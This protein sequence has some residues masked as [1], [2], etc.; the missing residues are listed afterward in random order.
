MSKYAGNNLKQENHFI[1]KH[2]ILSAEHTKKTKVDNYCPI[3][4]M[5]T[6]LMNTKKQ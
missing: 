6:I 4:I 5:G 1:K 3:K 2:K